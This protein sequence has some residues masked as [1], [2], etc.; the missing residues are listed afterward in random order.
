MIGNTFHQLFLL[1]ADELAAAPIEYGEMHQT[2]GFTKD[3]WDLLSQKECW[4]PAQVMNLPTL[5]N[6]LVSITLKIGGLPAVPL[7]GAF[8]AASICKN[9][10][11]CNRLLAAASAPESF[12]AMSASGI[13]GASVKTI[14]SKEQMYALVIYMSSADYGALSSFR[15]N[16]EIEDAVIAEQLKG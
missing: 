12:D 14:T 3:D 13:L 10:A 4:T 2:A 15:L 5:I 6:T 9:I 7:P 11:P 1:G 8:V 16:D